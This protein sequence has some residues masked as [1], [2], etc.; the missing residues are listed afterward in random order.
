MTDNPTSPTFHTGDLVSDA[1]VFGYHDKPIGNADHVGVEGVS[2]D[3]LDGMAHLRP[4]RLMVLSDEAEYSRTG[5]HHPWDFN[6]SL[7]PL[8]D[9]EIAYTNEVLH[10][11]GVTTADIDE[12]ALL[13]PEPEAATT[14]IMSAV[15]DEDVHHFNAAYDTVKTLPIASQYHVRYDFLSLRE[16]AYRVEAMH[17]TGYGTSPLHAALLQPTWRTGPIPVHL[18]FKCHTREEYDHALNRLGLNDFVL[19][20]A[21]DS[22]Y[23]IFSYWKH[24][25][26]DLYIKPRVNTRDA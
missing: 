10:E 8:W 18:S 16:R 3:N 20:Q 21:C 11:M 7:V 22:T 6:P 19:A 17:L 23:G 26:F 15:C 12:I 2:K 4:G 14:W 13:F 25:A 24:E 9:K 5:S 1:I